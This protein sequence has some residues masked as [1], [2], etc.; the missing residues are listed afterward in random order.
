M[1][2]IV[3][4]APE[5][6]SKGGWVLDT[7][8]VS[9]MGV[10]YLLAHGLGTP[11]SDAHTPISVESAGVYHL[12]VYT[13]NWIAP[14]K[15]QYAPGVFEVK[16]DEQTVPFTFGQTCPEWGWEYGG[17]ISL[18]QGQ[19]TLTFHDL[20]GFEGRFGLVVLTQD[21]H[22]TLPKTAE[23]ITTFC[24]T[25]GNFLVPQDQGDFDLVVCGG[26]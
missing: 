24:Y 22:I 9:T 5:F 26:G 8:F 10:P 2:T 19:H 18:S 4:S 25:S 3:I 17:E 6:S 1:K 11:V 13:Y 7:Q 14:W 21:K 12:F 23:D 20:T 15:P 16:I